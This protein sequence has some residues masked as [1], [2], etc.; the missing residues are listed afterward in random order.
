MSDETLREMFKGLQHEIA[1]SAELTRSK[2]R[3]SVAE[4]KV[5]VTTVKAR[6]DTVEGTVYGCD[7]AGVKGLKTQFIEAI[8]AGRVFKWLITLV[9][10]VL[11]G[12]RIVTFFRH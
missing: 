3:E 6:L 11:G 9:T 1:S 4:I 12:D 5:D 8:A 2:V 7:E 10:A